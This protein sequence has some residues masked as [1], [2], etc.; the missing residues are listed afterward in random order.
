MIFLLGF[1]SYYII[2][3]LCVIL[4][5]LI[6]FKEKDWLV[7]TMNK[8]YYLEDEVVEERWMCFYQKK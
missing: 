4:S 8:I 5:T 3:R 6:Q 2:D 1:R 7:W